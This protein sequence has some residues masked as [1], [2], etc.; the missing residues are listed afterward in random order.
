MEYILN[1]DDAQMESNQLGQRTSCK[2]QIL[3]VDDEADV[4]KA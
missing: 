4:T 3:R 2:R 1:F